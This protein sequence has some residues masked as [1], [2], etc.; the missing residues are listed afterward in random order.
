MQMKP[1]IEFKLI[2]WLPGNPRHTRSREKFIAYRFQPV[3]KSPREFRL[4]WLL[5]GFVLDLLAP[6]LR[7]DG[8]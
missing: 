2:P 3:E 7:T 5:P 1:L 6:C 8:L 4:A